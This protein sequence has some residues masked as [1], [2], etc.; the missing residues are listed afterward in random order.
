MPEAL[1]PIGF[2]IS[3]SI[4]S[5]F[6]KKLLFALSARIA[7][8]LMLVV[9][10]IAHFTFTPGMEMM[11]PDFIPY[12]TALVYITGILEILAAIGILIP[13]YQKVTG[14]FIVLFF[15]AIIP[16]NIYASMHH[17]DIEHANYQG[18]GLEY[19]WYRIPLQLF[20]I[21]WVYLCAIKN[22]RATKEIKASSLSHL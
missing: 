5:R 18:N 10:G 2:L 15:I 8:A 14:W 13:K 17:V 9:T 11:L 20:F 16:A 1:L 12:K 22:W 19:L 4:I 3:L 21:A 6:R 7:M